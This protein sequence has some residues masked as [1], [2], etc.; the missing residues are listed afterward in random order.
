MSIE[1]RKA[2]PS[3]V[4][5]I[6]KILSFYFLDTSRVE[7]NLPEFRVAVLDGRIIGCACL[8]L[9]DI[10]ELQSIAVLPGYRYRGIGSKLVDAI[11]ARAALLTDV[12]YLRTTLPVFFEKK[13]FKRLENDMKKVI[14]KDCMECDKFNMCRQAL[15]VLNMERS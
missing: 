6:K 10:V 7:E 12:I 9:G 13:G 3:D 1:I 2:T 11:L 8:E 15:M 4:K 5:E 14:W